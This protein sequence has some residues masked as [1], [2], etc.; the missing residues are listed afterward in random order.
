MA[1][2]AR[3]LILDSARKSCSIRVSGIDAPVIEHR[4][5]A[6]LEG[7]GLRVTGRRPIPD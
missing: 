3:G 6:A 1:M 2:H 7:F 5:L 4:Q